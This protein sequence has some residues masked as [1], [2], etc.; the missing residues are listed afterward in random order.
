MEEDIN[1]RLLGRER[2]IESADWLPKNSP[3]LEIF[4]SRGS[5]GTGIPTVGLS[6]G[7]SIPGSITINL[8]GS[9]E[10][11]W[12]IMCSTGLV[13]IKT[14]GEFPTMPGIHKNTTKVRNRVGGNLQRAVIVS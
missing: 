6:H 4:G 14:N 10:V 5:S 7:V 1:E 2:G 8:K 11:P 9:L 13:P 3:P 12:G